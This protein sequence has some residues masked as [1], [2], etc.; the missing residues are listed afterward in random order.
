MPEFAVTWDRSAVE[1]TKSGPEVVMNMRIARH[2][3]YYVINYIYPILLL[4]LLS[5]LSF[6][7]PHAASDRIA[8]NMTLLLTLM[9]INFITADKRPATHEDMWLDNFQ[10]I[11]LLLTVLATFYSVLYVR[12]MPGDDWPEERKA[13]RENHL[14]R[15]D[16]IAR[17]VFPVLGVLLLAWIFWELIFD[18]RGGSTSD[19]NGRPALMT[20][21]VMLFMACV[22][23]CLIC[24][25]RHLHMPRWS[26]S[27]GTL[28][29][30]A[31]DEPTAGTTFVTCPP[32]FQP[33]QVLTTPTTD[34]RLMNVAVP[35]GVQPGQ[36]F[37]VQDPP[38]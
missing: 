29:P 27:L 24:C 26:S 7:L 16:Q 14:E 20:I 36:R 8:F 23:C 12:M 32:G 15:A 28:T 4:V 13:T 38:P 19:F 1:Q 30:G 2:A 9:A 35:P 31:S 25:F 6:Y 5:W 21:G 22:L 3:D 33:G 37:A 11:T 34:G 10:T 18:A 17:I